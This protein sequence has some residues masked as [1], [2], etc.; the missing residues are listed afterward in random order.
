MAQLPTVSQILAS[1]LIASSVLLPFSTSTPSVLAQEQPPVPTI[2]TSLGQRQ[3]H[4]A[5]GMVFETPMGFSEVKNL[6][7]SLLGVVARKGNRQLRIRLGSLDP[8]LLDV[9]S[10]DDSELLGY[11]KQTMLGINAPAQQF[12]ERE[13]LDQT[14]TGEVHF[15]RTS[16]GFTAME[17]YL[18]PLP[19]GRK[20]IVSLEADPDLPLAQVDN[21]FQT[22]A[23]S[24]QE[25][26]ETL[27]KREKRNK[28]KQ[29]SQ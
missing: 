12:H 7:N 19:D 17:I 15:K 28:R 21:A 24:L 22:M 20:L 1:G 13:F 29:R 3:T 6:G 16:R 5:Q 8:G 9:L 27:E 23:S 25:A 26:P 4:R 11:V 18:V 10:M 14:L 2:K